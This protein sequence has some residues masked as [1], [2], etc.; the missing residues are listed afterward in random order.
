MMVAVGDD[1]SPVEARAL[2]AGDLHAPAVL[3]ALGAFQRWQDAA[4]KRDSV[5]LR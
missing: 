2:F 4:W 3:S 5:A 1:E